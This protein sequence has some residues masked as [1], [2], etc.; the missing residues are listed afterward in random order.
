GS[1][2]MTTLLAASL[3]LLPCLLPGIATAHAELTIDNEQWKQDYEKD[4]VVVYTHPVPGSAFQA[5]KA[6]YTLDASIDEIMAVMSDPTSC[7]QWVH[8]CVESWGFD[9]EQ[10]WKRYA[11]S[12]NDLPWPVTDRDYVLEINTSKAADSD[13]IVMDLYAVDKKIEPNKD[14]VRVRQQETHYHIKPVGE[15]RTEITWLQHTEPGGAIPG[16]LVN[17][18]IVDI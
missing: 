17:A 4:G 18:L 15:E 12:V 6:I 5:F 1:V 3:F 2:H 13:T 14:Y 16:W 11:Y 8:N 7:T 10:F 9:D